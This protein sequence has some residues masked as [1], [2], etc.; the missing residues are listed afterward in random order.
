MSF[1]LKRDPD[2]TV[3]RNFVI[4]SQA[5]TIGDSVDISRT[6]ADVVPSTA[7]S[8]TLGIR[9]ISNQTV[10]SAATQLLVTLVTPRQEWSAT[11]TNAA[12]AAHNGQ[13]MILTD[14]ATVN[15]TGTDSTTSSGVFEQ[16]GVINSTTILGRFLAV[17]N[18]TA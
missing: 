18:I 15:N 4:A 10:T 3:L 17:A 8:T 11:V 7:T 2:N 1:N 6:A 12:N 9:G 14:K 13:R 16:L 5:Y